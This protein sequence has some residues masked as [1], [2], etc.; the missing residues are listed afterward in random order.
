MV[1]K[2]KSQIYILTAIV[3]SLVVF[4]LSTTINEIREKKIEDNF[5]KISENYALEGAKLVNYLL[6]QQNL[7]SN[8]VFSSFQNFTYL[9]TSYTKSLTQSFGVIY[10]LTYGNNIQIG[11]YMDR[12][13]VIDKSE[14]PDVIQD[15]VIL[16]GCYDKLSATV[17][18][19]GLTLAV[20]GVTVQDL[21]PCTIIIPYTEKIWVNIEDIWYPFEIVE[22]RP[23]IMVVS[24]LEEKE[25]RK[26]YVGGEGFTKE[27]EHKEKVEDYCGKKVG[28]NCG[29]SRVCKFEEGECDPVWHD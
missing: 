5:K 22:D 28:Q 29:A 9:Y 11:N 10:A 27:N 23:Q 8:Y 20:E 24:R 18:F 3:I 21:E 4:I 13:I 26:V 15:P 19:E 2:K 12:P 1:N 16:N 7:S 14:N 25:Q 6:E 17:T